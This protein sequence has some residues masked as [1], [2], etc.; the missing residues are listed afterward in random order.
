[1]AILATLTLASTGLALAGQDF[2]LTSPAMT[3]G[4]D[5]PAAQILNGFG[6]QGANRSPALAWSAPPPGTQSLAVTMY[7]PDA[8]SGSGWWH[9]TVFNL[10]PA[11]RAFSEGEGAPQGAALPAGAV[12][13]RT[14]FGTPG[15]GGACP[16]AGD[17]P[18][19]YVITI[20][21][22]DTGRL[23]LDANAPGAMVG[24]FLHRHAISKATLTVR[25]G[26]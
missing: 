11:T 1:M 16:P 8:P 7:D 5:L 13:G 20:W 23:P 2:T 6:C 4:G 18:H 25:Y 14:D 24:F 21:A 12:Q 22:L 10:P 9:W 15:Y 26:R 3:D 19:R 17:A